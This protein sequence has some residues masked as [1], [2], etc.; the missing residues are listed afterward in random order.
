[1]KVM[2]ILNAT[3]DS[4]SD[5]GRLD[6][7]RV[8]ASTIA[9][10]IAAGADC[11]DVGGES[12]R[13]GHAPVPPDEEATRVLRVIE[14]IRAQSQIPISID[15]QKAAVAASALDA[16]A[17]MVNDVSGLGDPAMGP[18][19]AGR[20][21]SIVLMR[22]QDLSGDIVAACK[23]E[24]H[25]IIAQAANAGIRR[26]QIILDPGL[27]FGARPGPHVDD[28]MALVDGV[29][30]YDHGLPVLI[31]GSRKRFIGAMMDETDPRRRL[32]GNLEVVRRA[33]AAGAAWVRVHDVAET[34]DQLRS[35]GLSRA[36]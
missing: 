3:P 10:M 8:L 23:A 34:V 16:G 25:D 27:G 21:C 1:M 19:V 33:H 4:F 31:G 7:D 22:H 9:T 24:L 12:T 36:P 2:G 17:T 13:P 11:L 29:A 30:S 18:L 5:G 15:T 28:N 14:A 32:A 20:G 26:S 6:D 35:I